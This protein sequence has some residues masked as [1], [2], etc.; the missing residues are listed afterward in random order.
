MG[1]NWKASYYFL[2]I[3]WFR[4]LKK[5]KI[6]D[7]AVYIINYDDNTNKLILI[8]NLKIMKIIIITLFHLRA[9][10]AIRT[11]PSITRIAINAKI[12]RQAKGLFWCSNAFPSYYFP[13]LT[14]STAASRLTSIL[15]SNVPC[16]ITISLNYLYISDNSFIVSTNCKIYLFLVSI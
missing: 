7:C 13:F 9:C 3:G 4:F 5:L 6:Y 11:I 15:S 16:K 12:I 10:F 14:S 8:N 1:L 2:L